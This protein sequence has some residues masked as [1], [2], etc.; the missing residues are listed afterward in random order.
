M[1]IVEV[2]VGI[3]IGMIV[4]VAIYNVFSVAEGYKRTAVG[5]ADAQTTGLFA[6][7]IL[8]REIANAGN[9]DLAAMAPS[10]RTCTVAD[11]KW[12]IPAGFAVR[13]RRNRSVRF[14][15]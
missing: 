3:L 4:V 7:F 11:P 14:P 2:M 13:R 12:P 5:A 8:A 6:Q 1:G 9:G 10:S 15:C